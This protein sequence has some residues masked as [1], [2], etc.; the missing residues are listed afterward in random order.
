MDVSFVSTDV[1]QPSKKKRE[2]EPSSERPEGGPGL[3]QDDPPEL[4]HIKEEEEEEEEQLRGLQEEADIIKLTFSPVKSEEDDEEKPHSS[5][6]HRPGRTKTDE[7]CG[8]PEPARESDPDGLFQP[9][10]HDEVSH[11]ETETDDSCD[12]EESRDHRSALHRPHNNQ[13]HVQRR[14]EKTSITSECAT[15][16]VPEGQQLLGL[17]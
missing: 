17:W 1:Q 16:S 8:R 2:D 11:S 14:T 5:Q 10:A 4:Q 12:W 3:D 9:D 6:L 15:S 13:V 7:D